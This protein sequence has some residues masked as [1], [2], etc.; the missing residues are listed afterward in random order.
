MATVAVLVYWWVEATSVDLPLVLLTGF[1]PPSFLQCTD[2]LL[3]MLNVHH[4]DLK[5]METSAIYRKRSMLPMLYA[6]IA[7]NNLISVL[8]TPWPH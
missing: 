8:F 6:R 3:Q 5:G 1:T 4:F 7:V 2:Q